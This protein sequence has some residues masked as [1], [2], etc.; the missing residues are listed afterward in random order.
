MHV[1]SK[2]INQLLLF[3]TRNF[4]CIL[5]KVHKQVFFVTLVNIN[6]KFLNSQI[7]IIMSATFT[8]A[9]FKVLANRQ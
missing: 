7:F 8:D 5:S 1:H 9:Y 4:H 2:T 6:F 3:V